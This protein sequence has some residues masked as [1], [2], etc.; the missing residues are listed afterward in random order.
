MINKE[1]IAIS[2]SR[3]ILKKLDARIDGSVI[4]SRSQ[5]IELFIKKGM[6]EKID[7]AVIMISRRHHKTALMNFKG[8]ALIRK[9]IEFFNKFGI[10]NIFILTQNGEGI[11]LLKK[12]CSKN[13]KII[14]TNE[15][16]N[17]DALRQLRKEITS[18][19]F[20]VSGDI[21]NNFDMNS[22]IRK[23]A[24]NN[25]LA[26]VGLMSKGSPQKYGTAVL[27]GDL[28]IDFK[29]KPKNPSSFIVNSGIYIFKPEAFDL[30]KG[31]IEEDVL[32]RL[33]RMKELIGF[34]TT[35]EYV[36]FDEL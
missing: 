21:Y 26:T 17:G 28:V 19:F 29:E 32:P 25:K 16:S 9:Q 2:L 5:A 7:T 30:I 3:D 35:G 33:A 36:H 24:I 6:E 15:K 10:S 1:K 34:F 8:S 31:S 4:R 23:H 13:E 27:D 11:E 20:A 22:M 14:T 12:E 18:D